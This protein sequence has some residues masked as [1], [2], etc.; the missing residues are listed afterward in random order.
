M[1]TRAA[2]IPTAS[3]IRATCQ[4]QMF[5]RL[6]PGMIETFAL[7]IKWIAKRDKE[8]LHAALFTTWA[9]FEVVC[10]YH[11]KPYWLKAAEA[12]KPRPGLVPAVRAIEPRGSPRRESGTKGGAS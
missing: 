10:K 1:K 2:K 5:S 8:N 4:R 3:Q 11:G 6:Q 12:D 7:M 9:R